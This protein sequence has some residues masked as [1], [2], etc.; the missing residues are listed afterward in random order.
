MDT[1]TLISV[2]AKL[3]RGTNLKLSVAIATIALCSTSPAHAADPQGARFK[4]APQYYPL[5]QPR[6]PKARYGTDV[7][8]PACNQPTNTSV[9]AGSVPN[10]H[11]ILGINP[12]FIGQ[13]RNTNVAWQTP[14]PHAIPAKQLTFNAQPPSLSAPTARL[15]QPDYESKSFATNKVSARLSSPA[16]KHSFAAKPSGAPNNTAHRQRAKARKILKYDNGMFDPSS[17]NPA[18]YVSNSRA[19]TSLSGKVL[20]K[21]K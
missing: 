15:A 12:S 7:H 5:E 21:Q 17:T 13:S 19:T 4:F 20:P 9:R 1:K 16:G 18:L 3:F 11:S 8:F 6:F 2:S 10:V 14:A